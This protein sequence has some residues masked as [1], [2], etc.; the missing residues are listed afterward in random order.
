MIGHR[1][2]LPASDTEQPEDPL[3]IERRPGRSRGT[4]GTPP[5]RRVERCHALGIEGDGGDRQGEGWHHRKSLLEML[6]PGDAEDAVVL[7]G[8]QAPDA[9]DGPRRGLDHPALLAGG[10]PQGADHAP[11]TAQMRGAG[12][13]G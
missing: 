3:D 7:S 12:D 1:R 4:G 9:G 13:I 2:C 8:E 5:G 10:S 6:E 11:W